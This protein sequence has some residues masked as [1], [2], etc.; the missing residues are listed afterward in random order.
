MNSEDRPHS[1]VAE[2][3]KKS[4]RKS[5]KIRGGPESG[6]R[7]PGYLGIRTRK[8]LLAAFK[9]TAWNGFGGVMMDG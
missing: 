9:Q 2:C 1:P 5:D 6:E 4:K 3:S 8:H 7:D